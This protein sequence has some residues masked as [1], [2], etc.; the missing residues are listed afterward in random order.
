M[1]D[2]IFILMLQLEKMVIVIIDC[3]VVPKIIDYNLEISNDLVIQV[4][5]EVEVV[6]DLGI[7]FLANAS[8]AWD[9]F[10]LQFIK[11]YPTHLHT[12][13]ELIRIV[14]FEHTIKLW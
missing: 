8:E 5:F 3:P 13:Y 6:R 2:Q 1:V 12:I 7:P 10:L 4:N 9:S 14:N 11:N